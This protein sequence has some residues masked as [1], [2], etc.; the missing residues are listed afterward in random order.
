[1]M[2][3]IDCVALIFTQVSYNEFDL[4][5]LQEVVDTIDISNVQTEVDDD[6]VPDEG[7]TTI[8]EELTSE[9][10]TDISGSDTN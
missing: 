6:D 10:P 7:I 1:M 2:N 3:L 8:L 5:S 9:I 4:P